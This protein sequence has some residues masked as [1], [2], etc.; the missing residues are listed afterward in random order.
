MNK[1]FASVCWLLITVL[2]VVQLGLPVFVGSS[3]SPMT[4]MHASM[5]DTTEMTDMAQMDVDCV[6]ETRTEQSAS[7]SHCANAL[8]MASCASHCMS[9]A[10]LAVLTSRAPLLTNQ[11][12]LMSELKPKSSA[13]QPSTPPPKSA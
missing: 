7:S 11:F 5:S 6:H 12:D 4:T 8:C 10:T 13:I 9:A 1:Y 3:T 2:S